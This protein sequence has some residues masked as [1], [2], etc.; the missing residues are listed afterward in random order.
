VSELAARSQGRLSGGG[1][2]V[3]SDLRRQFCALAVL[4]RGEE[5]KQESGAAEIPAVAEMTEGMVNG[6]GA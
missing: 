3:L 1:V 6:F 2:S 4:D 5:I